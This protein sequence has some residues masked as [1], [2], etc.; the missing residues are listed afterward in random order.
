MRKMQVGS[1]AALI[2]LI[3][4]GEIQAQQCSAVGLAA[5]NSMSGPISPGPIVNQA[6]DSGGVMGQPLVSGEV[7]SATTIPSVTTFSTQGQVLPYSYWVSAPQPA[8]I[9]VEYWTTDQ[10]PFRGRAYGSPNDRWSWYYMGG[11]GSRYL[12]KYYYPILR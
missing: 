2:S 10:F 3:L 6:M 9:Y 4:I 1:I 5:G 8:R 11:G 12:A 7:L